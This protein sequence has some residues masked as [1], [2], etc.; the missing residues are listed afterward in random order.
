MDDFLGRNESS[1]LDDNDTGG[2]NLESMKG[3]ITST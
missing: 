2:L 3:L 1:F